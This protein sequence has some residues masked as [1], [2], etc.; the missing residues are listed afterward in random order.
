MQK[1]GQEVTFRSAVSMGIGSMVGA[2]IFALLGTAGAI[3]GSAVWISFLL[4]G[5]I[6]LLSGYSFGR[7]GARY[8]A[9]GGLVEY[10]VQAYGAGRFSGAMGVMMYIGA[11]IAISLV[12]RTFGTYAEALLPSGTPKIF[13]EIFAA[14]VILVFVVI[15]L[16]GARAMA[17]TEN[18]VVLVKVV[19]LVAFAGT[20][21][22][23][24]APER[25]SPQ[26]YPPVSAIFYSI[27]ITFFAFE[28]FRIIT[29]AAE[30]MKD[31]ARTLP[32]AIMVAI[33][34]VMVLYIATSLAVFGNLPPEKVIAAKDFALAEAAR[35][36]FGQT[37][38]AIVSVAA[39]L[40]T[41]SAINASLYAVTNVTYELARRGEL[42]HPFTKPIGHSREG[43]V[44]SSAFIIVLAVF[45][46]LSAIAEI[47][48]VSLLF[49]HLTVHIGHLRLLEET[50]ASRLIVVLA[51][52]TNAAAVILGCYHL[53]TTSP[54]LLV[55]IVGFFV[56]ALGADT[57]LYYFT[58]REI[59]ARTPDRANAVT[60]E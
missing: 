3:A 21:L 49:I 15:N 18:I 56:F 12:A 19:V 28:G 45:F 36:V 4:A 42:P 5:V 27:A 26:S 20:G 32:R 48:A 13:V 43:L 44:I 1:S 22:V 46:D 35:P 11:L 51:V 54:L 58:G 57:L 7:L 59:K 30:D 8:P 16:D 29:N 52:L 17:R 23:F 55:W 31:P 34:S 37:G 33:G 10:L 53:G 6:G 38:F 14:A 41:A 24:V 50:G 60:G 39:L 47:G 25:L 2:G 40:A 9:A